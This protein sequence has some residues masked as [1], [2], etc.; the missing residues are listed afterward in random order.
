MPSKKVFVREY[1]VRAHERVIHTRLYKFICASCHQP[2][3]RESFGPRPLY[4]LVCRPPHSPTQTTAHKK[5]KPRP[6]Q[7]LPARNR[8]NNS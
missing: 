8:R 1:T 2:T 7:V 6:V 3:E 4:C 5:K